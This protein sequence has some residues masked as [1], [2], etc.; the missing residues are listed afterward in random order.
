[1]TKWGP[2]LEQFMED[3]VP[4]EGH[5]A[6]A[7]AEREEEGAAETTCDGLNSFPVPLCHSGE[8]GK[9]NWE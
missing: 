3:C 2:T 6:G 5:H 4:W 8:G 1:V 9:E 7:G